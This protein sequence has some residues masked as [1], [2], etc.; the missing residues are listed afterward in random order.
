MSVEAFCAEV[1][2]ECFNRRAVGL[3]WRE[4]V[5]RNSSLISLQFRSPCEANSMAL[6]CTDRCRESHLLADSLPSF[7]N[8]SPSK[9]WIMALIASVALR[10]KRLQNIVRGCQVVLARNLEMLFLAAKARRRYAPSAALVFECLDIH[11]LLL[12]NSFSSRLLR[13]IETRLVRDV[14]LILT[15]SPRF[16]SEYFKPRNFNRPIKI[17]ENKV[18]LSDYGIG[19]VS[20]PP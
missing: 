6:I 7:H 18:L 19:R 1:T 14:D 3:P 10:L 13:S 12:R 2:A 8:V 5:Q 9:R 20:Q 15:S 11:R 4:K 16:V 17:L